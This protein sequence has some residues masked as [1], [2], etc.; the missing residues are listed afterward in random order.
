MLCKELQFGDWI[1]DNNGFPMQITTVGDDYA[2]ATFE[3]NEGDPWEFDD[4]DDQ[5]QPISLTSEILEKNGWIQ[6]KYETCK[7]LYEYKGLHLRHTMIKRSN[8]RWV[9]NV[10]G[11]VE[12]FPDEYTHSFLR[13]N[14][15]YVHELQHVLRIAGMTDLANNF[16]VK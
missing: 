1:T 11:I 5:P 10:D 12:K 2:Y 4:K 13:I 14:V 16:K 9:A 8:G 3:G 15:F 6:C 7:S